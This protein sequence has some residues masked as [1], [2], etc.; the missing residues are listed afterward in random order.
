MNSPIVSHALVIVFNLVALC[1]MTCAISG[2]VLFL[3]KAQQVNAVM[4][5]PLLEHRPFKAY[6]F[7]IQASIFLDYFLRLMFP[8]T[9][10]WLIGH[11]NAQLKHVDP[12]TVPMSLKWPI[13]GFWGSCWVG[14][15][16]MITLWIIITLK[17]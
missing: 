4:R 8:R 13:V 17:L 1:F 12:K 15:L 6:P 14:L 5:H 11:A 10:F 16:A 2:L 3:F 9:D 7:S